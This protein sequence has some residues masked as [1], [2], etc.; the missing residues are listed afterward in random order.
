MTKPRIIEKIGRKERKRRA[1]EKRQNILEEIWNVM[2]P[3]LKE[4]HDMQKCLEAGRQ[5]ILKMIYLDPQNR[6]LVEQSV[7][8]LEDLLIKTMKKIKEGYYA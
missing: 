7:N 3:V 1:Q 8:K 4:T 6:T 2:D 5:K